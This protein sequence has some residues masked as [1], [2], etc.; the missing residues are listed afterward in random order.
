MG[1]NKRNWILQHC[2]SEVESL[3]WIKAIN[4]RGRSNLFFLLIPL[5]LFLWDFNR[6]LSD[7]AERKFAVPGPAFESRAERIHF[8]GDGITQ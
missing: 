5:C 6:K 1:S 3:L 4:T 2:L 7:E 8:A